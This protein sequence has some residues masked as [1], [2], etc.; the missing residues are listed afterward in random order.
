M[1]LTPDRELLVFELEEY[2]RDEA[3][4][5]WFT[6]SFRVPVPPGLD[7]LAVL[8]GVEISPGHEERATG[9]TA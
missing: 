8:A 9:R 7:V 3:E 2:E 4:D 1:K 5:R 6:W